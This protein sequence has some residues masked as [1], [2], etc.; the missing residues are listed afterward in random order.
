MNLLR[1]FQMGLTVR[2]P[3]KHGRILEFHARP[4]YK[5]MQITFAVWPFY[6]EN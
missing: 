3:D 5:A 1:A 6:A 2:A 4:L